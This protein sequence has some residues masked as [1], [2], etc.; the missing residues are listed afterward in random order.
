MAVRCPAI[1]WPDVL[2][3]CGPEQ[4]P[5]IV[6]KGTAHIGATQL[7][8]VAIRI[9]PRFRRTPDYKPEVPEAAYD[10]EALEAALD[11]LEYVIEALGAVT[12]VAEQSIVNLPGGPYVIWMLPAR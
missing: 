7:E 1:K 3:E 2:E 12:G 9:D 10:I 4:D 11:E 8:V 5:E 6:L